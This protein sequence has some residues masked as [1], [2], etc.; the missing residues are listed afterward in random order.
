MYPPGFPRRCWE[1]N[2]ARVIRPTRTGAS[3][4]AGPE[5]VRKATPN[6]GAADVFDG[7]AHEDKSGTD[8]L[9]QPPRNDRRARCGK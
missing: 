5:A 9:S 2:A 3:H 1:E 7:P 8:D 4:I 6:C